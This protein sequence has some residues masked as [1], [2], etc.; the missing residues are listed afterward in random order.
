MIRT[1]LSAFAGFVAWLIS[2][3][4]IEKLLS[5]IGPEWYGVH[6]IAFEAAII[7]G[8]QF[9]ANTT[10]LLIQI[11]LASIISVTSGFLTALIAGENRRAPLFLGGLILC[12]GLMKVVMSWP[13]VPIWHHTM[14]LALLL[15]LTIWGG[16]L[17]T[18]QKKKTAH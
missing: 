16:K 14:F 8:G 10:L 5:A 3:F 9:T 13:Y 1:V 18:Y 17:K 12:L 15:P 11:V 6:Q 2:W 4:G 7:D